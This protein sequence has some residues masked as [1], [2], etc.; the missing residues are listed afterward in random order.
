MARA[1]IQQF[2]AI[3]YEF[4]ILKLRLFILLFVIICTILGVGFLVSGEDSIV[5]ILE[6]HNCRKLCCMWKIK[7]TISFSAFHCQNS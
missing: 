2:F 1:N 5:P 4:D 3:E 7:V 6:V